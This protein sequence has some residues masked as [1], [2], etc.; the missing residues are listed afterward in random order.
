[1]HLACDII[2]R[3]DSYTPQRLSALV[4]E[5]GVLYLQCRRGGI[6]SRLLQLLLEAFHFLHEMQLAADSF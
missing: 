6:L 5:H 4:Q 2:R 1:M 3:L